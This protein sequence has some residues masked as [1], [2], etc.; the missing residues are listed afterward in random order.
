MDPATIQ[1]IAAL[2]PAAEQIAFTIGQQIITLNTS[3]LTD[4]KAIQAALQQAA[5]E[6][7]PALSF[8]STAP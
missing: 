2:L 7:F 5:T 4:P 8:K 3:T 6:G 1:L